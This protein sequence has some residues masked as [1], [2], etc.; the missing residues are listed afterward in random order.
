M[1]SAA[2]TDD[3]G[4]ASKYKSQ[5]KFRDHDRHIRQVSAYSKT[6]TAAERTLL[7]KLRSRANT[8]QSGELSRCTRS[9]IP[10]TSGRRDS[11]D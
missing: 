10:S 8:N 2:D 1:R 4:K 7:K 9:T 3:K 5:A 11:K 6:K